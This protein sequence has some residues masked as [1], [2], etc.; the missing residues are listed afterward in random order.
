[1]KMKTVINKL[2]NSPSLAKCVEDALSVH[3]DLYSRTLEAGRHL[4]EATT[5][6]E[7]RSRLQSELQAVQEAWERNTSVLEQRRDLHHASVQV[8]VKHPLMAN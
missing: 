4:C 5:E 7:C 1:M 6:P 3:S 8:A 2:F